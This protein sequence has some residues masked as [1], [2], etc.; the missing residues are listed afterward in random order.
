MA[1]RI[2]PRKQLLLTAL[3]CLAMLGAANLVVKR[4]TAHTVSRRILADVHNAPSTQVIALGNSL[5]RSGFVPEV[6]APP[7]SPGARSAAF[8]LAMG[9]SLPPDQLLL[10]R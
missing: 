9:A 7:A 3:V 5:M 8:N 10:F 1:E 4:L 6:F 2:V